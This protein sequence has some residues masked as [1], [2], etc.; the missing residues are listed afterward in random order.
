MEKELAGKLTEH[1]EGFSFQYAPE[2]LRSGK[3]MPVSLTLLLQ[4]EPFHSQVMFSFFGGL[5]P[6]GW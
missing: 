1:E 6:E 4:A 3:A 2:Y 5:I